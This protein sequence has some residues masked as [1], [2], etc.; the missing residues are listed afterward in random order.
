MHQ[1]HSY[2]AAFQR[3]VETA[4][5]AMADAILRDL[6]ARPLPTLFW[7]LVWAVLAPAQLVAAQVF[8]ATNYF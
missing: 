6:D 4:A 3:Q 8:S 5:R 1:A 2:D 7:V